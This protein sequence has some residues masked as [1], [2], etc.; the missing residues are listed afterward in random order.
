MRHNTRSSVVGWYLAQRRSTPALHFQL[1][2]LNSSTP[3]WPCLPATAIR[4]STLSTLAPPWHPPSRCRSYSSTHAM[5]TRTPSLATAAGHNPTLPAPQSARWPRQ[6]LP[7]RGASPAGQ[8]NLLPEQPRKAEHRRGPGVHLNSLQ[9]SIPLVCIISLP[10]ILLN[11]TSL[12]F[13]I[14]TILYRRY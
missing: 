8:V 1:T 9:S 12:H 6:C 5:P 7:R 13:A 11:S 3:V 14:D 2:R 10:T 4:P